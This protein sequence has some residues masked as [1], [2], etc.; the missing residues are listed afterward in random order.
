MDTNTTTVDT[1]GVSTT[2]TVITAAA[3]LL[4]C[5]GAGWK[6]AGWTRSKIDARKDRKAN[7]AKETN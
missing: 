6:F 1:E 3:A 4:L 2:T 5:A 7:A